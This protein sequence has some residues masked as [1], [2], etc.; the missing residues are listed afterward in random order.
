MNQLRSEPGLEILVDDKRAR[1][2]AG[3]TVAAALIN[4]GVTELRS[5]VTGESR[6]VLCGMGVCF[7][8]RLTIDDRPHQRACL[9]PVADGMRIRTGSAR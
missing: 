3:I 4:L 7:E 6:G 9:I 2:P 8:C 5:S 1:V